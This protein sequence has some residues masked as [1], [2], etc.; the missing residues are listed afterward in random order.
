MLHQQQTGSQVGHL[1]DAHATIPTPRAGDD[2]NSGQ[3][4]RSLAQFLQLLMGPPKV[5]TTVREDRRWALPALCQRASKKS[6]VPWRTLNHS[7]L[8][9]CFTANEDKVAL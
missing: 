9:R 5:L 1:L 6:L 8:A 3:V 2:G 7:Y 4:L